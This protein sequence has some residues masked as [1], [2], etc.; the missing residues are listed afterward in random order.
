VLATAIIRAMSKA[1]EEFIALMLEA[2]GTSEISASLHQ[3][4]RRYMPKY[5]HFCKYICQI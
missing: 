5:S 1:R 3:T 2:A 4:T